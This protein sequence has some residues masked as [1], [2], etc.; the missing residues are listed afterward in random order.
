MVTPI[1]PSLKY[2]NQLIV[3]FMD[4]TRV[5]ASYNYLLV[6]L[7]LIL[8][9]ICYDLIVFAISLLTHNYDSFV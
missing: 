4:I 5:I 7:K 8:N 2:P 6:V 3:A 9:P 1:S